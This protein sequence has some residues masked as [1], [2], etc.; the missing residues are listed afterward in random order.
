MRRTRNH[1]IYAKLIGPETDSHQ[2]SSLPPASCRNGRGLASASSFWEEDMLSPSLSVAA[3]V[4]LALMFLSISP[5]T[6]LTIITPTG[7]R[8]AA[9]ALNLTGA[10]HCRR[11]LHRHKQGYPLSR[12]CG[13]GADTASPV[14]AP[15]GLGSSVTL[16]RPSAPLPAARPS[17]NYFNPSNPQDRSGNLNPQDMTQP[18]SFNPQDMRLR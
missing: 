6:S 5:A 2:I 4:G 11:Y 15:E 13:S 12:G 10:V 3:S 8:P 16:P 14:L 1:G 9:D 17:G 18:R 7:L